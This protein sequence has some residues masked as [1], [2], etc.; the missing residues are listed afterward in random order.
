M[1]PPSAYTQ[2]SEMYCVGIMMWELWTGERAYYYEIGDPDKPLNTIE[3]F[4]AYIEQ[5]RP[6]LDMF[7][8][9]SGKV[10]VSKMAESWVGRLAQCWSETD[11]INSKAWLQLMDDVRQETLHIQEMHFQ[12]S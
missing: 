10:A 3:K 11:R 9:G 5:N 12:T 6:K 2:L 4:V 7:Y 8:D 1:T